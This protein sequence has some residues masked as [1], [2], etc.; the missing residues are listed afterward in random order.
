MQQ[1]LQGGLNTSIGHAFAPKTIDARWLLLYLA[2]PAVV[3]LA[4]FM[5]LFVA[6]GVSVLL[7][8]A[9]ATLVA[10]G[11]APQ[12]TPIAIAASMCGAVVL[13][14][15]AGFPRG[16]FAWDWIKHWALTTELSTH[17]WPFTLDLQGKSAHIRF[18][19]GAYL[20]PALA[21]KVFSFISIPIALGCWFLLGYF[22]VLRTVTAVA[23]SRRTTWLVLAIFLTLG[24]ADLFAEHAYRAMRGLA[25]VPWLGLHYEAWAFNAFG[26]PIEFSSMLTA[27]LWVPHQSIATFI[28][29]AL[30]VLRGGPDTFRAAML[31][32][33]LLAIWSPYGM[34]GLLPLM[35]MVAWDRKAEL[36]HWRT[37]LCALASSAFTAVVAIYLSTELPS[38]GACFQCLPGRMLRFLDFAPFWIVELAA[39]AL[40]LQRRLLEDLSCLIS[41][42]TLLLL[43]LL[44]GQTPDLVMRASMGPLFVLSVRSAQVVLAWKVLP[45]QKALQILAISLC[46]PS[47]ASEVIYQREGG[48]AH[49]EL[50]PRDPLSAKWIKTFADRSDY[51]AEQFLEI[52][53]WEYRSQYFSRQKPR[54]VKG[55][56]S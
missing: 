35:L 15:L 21:H 31:G 2:A 33:G 56:A 24:G 7:I 55:D 32:C 17:E 28:V 26:A 22:L 1:S 16:P 52:C 37:L 12:R 10:S 45:W 30:L 51:T 9:L 50:S 49:Q 44:H 4:G 8:A 42:A 41:L 23:P 27:L 3:F 46:L 11:Q 54:L 6:I 40:I 43:P 18:Y 5:Q 36:K 25:S 38:A 19:I 39:F 48:A 47:A 14:W 29:A 53:G 20:V 13:A 34:I